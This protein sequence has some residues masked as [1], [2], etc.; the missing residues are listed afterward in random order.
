MTLVSDPGGLISQVLATQENASRLGLTTTL[1][2]GVVAPAA[3]TI[4]NVTYVLIDGDRS[5]VG[6]MSLVGPLAAGA[7][8]MVMFVRPQGAYIIG[9]VGGTSPVVQEHSEYQQAGTGSTVLATFVDWPATGTPLEITFN[10]RLSFTD[11]SVDLDCA[12]YGNTAG[13]G[14]AF[15]VE[16]TGV[17][18]TEAMLSYINVASSHDYRG[19]KGLRIAGVPAGETV[20]T[21]RARTLG[22]AALQ[23]DA[24]D[25]NA[26]T[27]REL[28]PI[29]SGS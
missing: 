12:F 15:G 8:V 19:R 25:Y 24:N 28:V 1:R 23:T 10:K 22:G 27:V 5:P 29:P 18:D 2:P 21:L 26:I 17:G 16:A 13:M 3:G 9:M 7:R 4:D 6:C 11:L 20:V 14:F